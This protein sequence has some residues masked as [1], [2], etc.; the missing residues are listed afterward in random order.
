MALVFLQLISLS[1]IPVRSIHVVTDGNI[2]LFFMPKSYSI[3]YMHHFFIYSSIDGHLGTPIVNNAAMNIWMC[4][5]DLVFWVSLDKY[6]EVKMLG[7]SLIL[8]LKSILSGI[9][10]CYPNFVLFPHVMKYL[11]PS[12]YFQSLYVFQSEVSLL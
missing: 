2:S 8:I 4:L 11:S 1:N 7:L 9:K 10:Y 6:Q 12:L 5:F 3:E